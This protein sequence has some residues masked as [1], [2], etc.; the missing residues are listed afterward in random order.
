VTTPERRLPALWPPTT[1]SSDNEPT[2]L[3]RALADAL[4]R[5]DQGIDAFIKRL[6]YAI[7]DLVG[8]K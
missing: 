3:D 7:E 6:N 2:R 1:V 4:M 5:Q 8:K